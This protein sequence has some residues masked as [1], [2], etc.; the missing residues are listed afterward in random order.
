MEKI[1]EINILLID[2]DVVLDYFLDRRPFSEYATKF[3][4][5]GFEEKLRLKA[6]PLTFANVYYLLRKVSPHKKVISALQDLNRMVDIIKINEES[7]NGALYSNWGDFEDALQYYSVLQY[8]SIEAIITRNTKDYKRSSL[9]VLTPAEFLKAR[10][11]AE[12]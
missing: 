7:V 11:A 4:D 10:K 6:T 9:P 1:Y 2:S 3:L 8:K 12:S 5:F